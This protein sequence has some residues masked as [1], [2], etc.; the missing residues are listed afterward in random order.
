M[1]EACSRFEPGQQ[2]TAVEERA[3]KILRDESGYVLVVRAPFPLQGRE[4]AAAPAEPITNSTTETNTA[5]AIPVRATQH[6]CF[7]CAFCGNPILL[8][9]DLMG[10]PFG[11]PY[12]RKISARSVATVCNRCNRVGNFS[13]FRGCNGFD[14]RHKMVSAPTLSRTVLLDWLQCLER[15]CPFRVPLFFNIP[16][17]A[18]AQENSVSNWKWDGLACASGHDIR[19]VSID[20]AKLAGLGS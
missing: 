5:P 9:H 20:L 15:S 19:H 11:S 7:Y 18:G 10:A 12:V 3:M 6:C 14:T 8:P 4:R 16:E 1:L 13:L 2:S 17:D